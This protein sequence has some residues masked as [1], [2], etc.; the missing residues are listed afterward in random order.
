MYMSTL[1]RWLW[2]F[3]WLLAIEFLG[4]L[5]TPVGYSRRESQISLWVVVSHH[6]VAGIW[7]Q[8]LWKSSWCSYLL[9]HLS[10]PLGNHLEVI[11]LSVAFWL[12]FVLFAETHK[13]QYFLKCFLY[14]SPSLS[15]SQGF[16]SILQA[17]LQ[18]TLW[19]RLALSSWVTL[20][21]LPHLGRQVYSPAS[22]L[23]FGYP[24]PLNFIL[25][26]IFIKVESLV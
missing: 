21:C 19:I 6:V 14:M 3:M 9:S 20:F 22:L 24:T 25:K 23:F 1:Y 15:S 8:D 16:Y 11:A 7:S 2:A 10:S 4:P 18:F 12:L 17:G 5:L 13:F 26:I